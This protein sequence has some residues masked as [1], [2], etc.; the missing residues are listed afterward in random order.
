MCEEDS[1]QL[2]TIQ[3]E[4][5]LAFVAG[6]SSPDGSWIGALWSTR[7]LRWEWID[8]RLDHSNLDLA[9]EYWAIGEPNNNPNRIEDC[10]EIDRRGANGNLSNR[11]CNTRLSFICEYST[12]EQCNTVVTPPRR[13][14]FSMPP[15]SKC[16]HEEQSLANAQPLTISEDLTPEEVMCPLGRPRHNFTMICCPNCTRRN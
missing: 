6:V 12:D 14:Y 3:S 8:K 7:S 2:A 1:G 13:G 9:S 11:N 5:E 4:Q 16:V 10:V 15:L